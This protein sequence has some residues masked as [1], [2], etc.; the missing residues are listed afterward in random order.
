MSHS[1]ALLND[2]FTKYIGHVQG[3]GRRTGVIVIVVFAMYMELP[4]LLRIFVSTMRLHIGLKNTF[5][6]LQFLW[7][8]SIAIRC[9][10]CAAREPQTIC[11]VAG[12]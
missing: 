5:S 6:M 7:R 8:S 2:F 3:A 11:I 12:S 9:V 1:G 10:P 4:D